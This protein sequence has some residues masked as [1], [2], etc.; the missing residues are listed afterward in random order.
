MHRAGSERNLANK[1]FFSSDRETETTKV[2]VGEHDLT[3]LFK[4]TDET[5]NARRNVPSREMLVV[6]PEDSTQIRLRSG[7]KPRE[8]SFRGN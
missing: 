2:L 4:R 7:R 5:T 8:R 1:R 3:F 6:G